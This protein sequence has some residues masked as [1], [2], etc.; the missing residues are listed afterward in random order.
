M[1]LSREEILR[2]ARHIILPE[3]GGRGQQR[4]KEGHVIITG[5][6]PT[7]AVAALYLAAAGVG[8]IDLYDQEASAAEAAPQAPDL[9]R[10]HGEEG[11]RIDAL[12]AKLRAINPDAAI[13]VLDSPAPAGAS[14]AVVTQGAATPF[15][16]A[17][18]PVVLAGA[19][20]MGGTVTVVEAGGAA[21]EGALTDSL[22]AALP[23]AGVIGSVAATEVVKLLVGTGRPLINRVLHYD[24][25]RTAF[26]ER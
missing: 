5:A 17:G 2:Y 24:G 3:I 4:L 1:S 26:T 23:A 20:R 11:A 22:D 19:G 7:G 21:P 10:W 16:A 25:L 14:L 12:A 15:L 13:R 6:G 9:A 8:R 18:L